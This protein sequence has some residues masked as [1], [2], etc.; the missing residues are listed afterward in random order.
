MSRRQIYALIKAKKLRVGRL[1]GGRATRSSTKSSG[2]RATPSNGSPARGLPKLP[3]MLL[4]ARWRSFGAGGP[5]PF[6]EEPASKVGGGHSEWYY[7]HAGGMYAPAR[8]TRSQRLPPGQVS[9]GI[10]TTTPDLSVANSFLSEAALI[11]LADRKSFGLA[12]ELQVTRF[13]NRR[14]V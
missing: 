7:R 9:I 4:L 3:D 12:V 10:F 2:S 11:S 6:C 14:G 8:L 13:T 5:F 1:C